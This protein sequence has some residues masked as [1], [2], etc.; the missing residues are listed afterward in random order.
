MAHLFLALFLIVFGLNLLFGL[1]I[2]IWVTGLL[3]L[4]AG[5]M[6]VLERFGLRVDRK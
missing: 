5:V 4:I 3:A 6:L 2:P 1:A